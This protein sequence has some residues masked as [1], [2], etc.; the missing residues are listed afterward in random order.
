MSS[1]V[2]TCHFVGHVV[3]TN[4]QEKVLGRPLGLLFNRAINANAQFSRHVR[5]IICMPENHILEACLE[6]Y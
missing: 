4:F 1:I 6:A 3:F 2:S 5:K